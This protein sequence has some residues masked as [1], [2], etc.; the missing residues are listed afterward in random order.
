MEPISMLALAVVLGAAGYAVT[1]LPS[2]SPADPM[3]DE[4]TWRRAGFV[5]DRYGWSRGP[6]RATLSETG[7][8]LSAPVADGVH[9]GVKGVHHVVQGIAL[10]VDEPLQL[11]WWDGETLDHARILD[12][13]GGTTD[14]GVLTVPA[15]LERLRTLADAVSG[16]TE[17]VATPSTLE[18]LEARCTEAGAVCRAAAV[19][20][21]TLA[22]ER[23]AKRVGHPDSS[24][25]LLAAVAAEDWPVVIAEAGRHRVDDAIHRVA[26]A[27]LMAACDS[28]P[29]L[30]ADLL[31]AP[32][33]AALRGEGALRTGRSEHLPTL[34]E[35]DG[36]RDLVL[37]VLDR[38]VSDGR[39]LPAATADL[40][41]DP[42]WAE[43]LAHWALTRRRLDVLPPLRLLRGERERVRE[44]LDF[45]A[46]E[47]GVN[48]ALADAFE[49]D[50]WWAV[51]HLEEPPDEERL[52]LL[53][54]VADDDEADPQAH[55]VVA[56]FLER[57]GASE[58]VPRLRGLVVS[59]VEQ[60]VAKLQARLVGSAGAVSVVAGG[61]GGLSV[62]D[63]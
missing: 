27:G 22:P 10:H 1:R 23:L 52:E 16:L 32:F 3:A 14:D 63:D 4:T 25:R 44:V 11:A 54:A 53:R 38:F 18:E 48:R 6:I 17:R 19:A 30:A 12:R 55:A 2:P 45:I 56:R 62:V 46:G 31:E 59:D 15:P 60:R 40:P 61:G 33:S 50:P 21:H 29:E 13:A 34:A 57:W 8:V 7:W 49:V 9:L 43:V 42:W 37:R 39:Q 28:D 36:E 20:L 35:L 51:A 24:I 47:T 5:R 26:V 41:M 58:D